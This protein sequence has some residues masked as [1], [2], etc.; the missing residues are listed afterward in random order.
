MESVAERYSCSLEYAAI[1][2]V[3]SFLV[4]VGLKLKTAKSRVYCIVFERARLPSPFLPSTSCRP[5]FR[6]LA[7]FAQR[8]Q[9]V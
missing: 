7:V 1:R 4:L 3:S 9:T 5:S 8:V 2:R 6:D